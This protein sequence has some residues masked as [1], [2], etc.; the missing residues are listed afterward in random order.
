[1]R[2]RTV[3]SGSRDIIECHTSGDPP[4]SKARPA[5]LVQAITRNSIR[6][7]EEARWFHAVGT[8]IDE[9]GVRVCSSWQ[10]A[11]ESASGPEW[12]EQSAFAWKVL[13]NHAVLSQRV[14]SWDRAHEELPPIVQSLVA[15]KTAGVLDD[16]GQVATLNAIIENDIL[17]VLVACEVLPELFD[18]GRELR[19]HSIKYFCYVDGRFPCG[20]ERDVP[21]SGQLV[22]Y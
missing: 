1:M 12:K 8:P 10:E 2:R 3:P 4:D 22:I 11:L 19:V 16:P 5:R 15:R 9:P 14:D 6:E 21:P 13:R 7:L 18:V 20:W 17:A